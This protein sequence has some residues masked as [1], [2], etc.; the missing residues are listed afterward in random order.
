MN[1][2]TKITIIGAGEIGKALEKILK[3]KNNELELWDKNPIKVP[4]QKNIKEIVPSSNFLFLCVPSWAIRQVITNLL[5]YLS[6]KTIVVSL[7]KGIEKKSF[8][9]MAEI[10]KELLPSKQPF[11]ILGGP[12]L[13][14]ELNKNLPT[15]GISASLKQKNNEKIKKLFSKTNLY[16]ETNTDIQGTA[17]AGALKNIYAIFLGVIDNLSLPN[18]I[19]QKKEKIGL[20]QNFKGWI[21]KQSVKEIT[22]II[23]LLGGKK[24]TGYGLAGLGDLIATGFSSYSSNYQI[25]KKI[26]KGEKINFDTEGTV[27]LFPVLQLLRKKNKKIPLLLLAI[28][29]I[30]INKKD[31]FKTLQ[32]IIINQIKK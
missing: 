32:G 18:T 31:P 10:L 2:K 13:A 3:N 11:C 4:C 17:L 1:N 5:P 22:E 14:E 15:I 8:K 24:Q 26:A 16:L 7:A 12:M 6:K 20:G 27:S 23:K 19:F 21:V 9:T 29:K 25:G 30:I 28:K